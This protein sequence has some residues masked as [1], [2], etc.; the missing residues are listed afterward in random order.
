MRRFTVAAVIVAAFLIAGTAALRADGKQV[1]KATVQF[2]EQV[3]LLN[4]ILKGEYLF[5][6]DTYK[7]AKGE[8]CTY[9]YQND[10]LVV[11]FHCEH[12]ERAKADQ[13]TVILSSNL[14]NGMPELLEFRF[15]GSTDG[16]RVPQSTNP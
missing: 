2:N 13:F 4:V 16:H 11:S 9:V 15:A 6:H 10:K 3:K 14:V 1:E 5:V 7:M 12:V 8:P